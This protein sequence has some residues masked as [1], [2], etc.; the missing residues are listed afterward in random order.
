M[1]FAADENFNGKILTGLIARLPDI[2]IVRVQDTPLYS[3][4]DPDLLAWAAQQARIVLTHDIQTLVPDAYSPVR[5][6][7]GMPGV[8][9]VS[10]RI[11]IGDAIDDLEILIGAGL[12]Q[13]FA[14]QV[15]HVPIR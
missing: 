15:W 5:E 7:L 12:P 13:D 11:S 4:T 6:M 3:A 8:I 1:R 10:T 14:Q 9:L 2:D